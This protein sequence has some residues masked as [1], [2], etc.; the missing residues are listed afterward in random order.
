MIHHHQMFFV[1]VIWWIATYIKIWQ[2]SN[3]NH[4]RKNVT[5]F[6]FSIEYVNDYYY[7]RNKVVI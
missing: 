4:C 1:S 5:G 6:V 3:I 2:N 7:L